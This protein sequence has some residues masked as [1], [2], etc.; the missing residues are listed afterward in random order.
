MT[1]SYDICWVDVTVAVGDARKQNPLVVWED[2]VEETPTLLLCSR[3]AS[4][5]MLVSE[6]KESRRGKGDKRVPDSDR[7]CVQLPSARVYRDSW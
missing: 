5:I 4:V 6:C 2:V 1:L 3:A 7:V